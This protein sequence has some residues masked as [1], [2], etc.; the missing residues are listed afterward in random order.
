[1][2]DA[3]DRAGLAAHLGLATG[4]AADQPMEDMDLAGPGC[5]DNLRPSVLTLPTR[6]RRPR[7]ASLY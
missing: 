1:M 2:K 5:S 7:C 3:L 4:L 6:F